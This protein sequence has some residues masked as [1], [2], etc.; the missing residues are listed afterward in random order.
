MHKNKIVLTVLCI[1]GY[2]HKVIQLYETTIVR[3]GLML[4]GPTG[5]GKTKVNLNSKNII[6]SYFIKHDVNTTLLQ[7]NK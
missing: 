1:I 2:V 4:V 7:Y 6:I 3:H 5:S